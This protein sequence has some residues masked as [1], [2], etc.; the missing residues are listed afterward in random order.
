MNE[1]MVTLQGYVGGQVKLRQAGDALVANFRVACT[2]RRYNRRTQEWFD[3]DTQ[4]YTVN[5]WRALGDHCAASLDSGDPVVVHGK[6]SARTFVNAQQ[7]EVTTFE[8]DA[9]FVGHDLNRGTSSFTKQARNESPAG[10]GQAG[11][12]AT[13][14]A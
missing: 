5:A 10:G 12:S 8:V 3:A 11:E 4:W 14:A 2:P 6:L 1:T 13:A 9:M 7:V